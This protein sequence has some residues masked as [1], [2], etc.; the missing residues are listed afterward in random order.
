MIATWPRLAEFAA[1]L[2][3]PLDDFQTEACRAVE[4]GRG[5]LVA[6][7]TG[8]GKTIVGEFAVHLAL[9]TGRKAFYTTPI[10]AL[11]NQKYADLVRR[12]GADRVGLL[13]GDSSINGEAPIV[14]M[15]TEVLRNMMYA[16]STTLRG[17][18]CV[19]MDEV[20]YLADRFR[21]AVWEE[22]IIHLPPEVQRRV[23]VGD[24]E[25]R[26]G[27]RRLARGGARRRRG[28]RL[29]APSRASV[30]A[31]DGRPGPLRPVRRGA[32]DGRADDEHSWPPGSL[33]GE[34]QPRPR[35]RHPRHRAS[36]RV[37]HAR[38]AARGS[39]QGPSRGKGGGARPG[40]GGAADGTTGPGEVGAAP[41]PGAGPVAATADAAS[42]AVASRWRGHARRGRRSGSTATDCCRRSPSSSAARAATAPSGSCCRAACA[43]SPSPEGEAHPSPRRGARPGL[44]GREED[45]TVLGYWDFVD[46]LD[47]RVRRP[48]RRDAA[49]LPRD[50]R[51]AVH[52]RPGPGRLRDRDAGAGHQHAGADGRAREAGEVQRRGPRRRHP[53]RVHPA[54][55]PGRAPGHR[56]RGPCRRAVEPRPRPAGR[57][58]P[59]LD[60]HLPAA[61][62]LPAD[63]QHGRQPRAPSSVGSGAREILETSFAQFQADRAVVGLRPHDPPQRGGP[64]RLRRAR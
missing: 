64:C 30:A 4:E 48:P 34:R 10:K 46:G 29:G 42:P 25:Q 47:P 32:S 31:H 21:G 57:R 35:A 20:H 61:V 22:V 19:V 58:R 16:G 5:V 33:L 6:A 45:L 43:S 39:R 37:G 2:E 23:A 27:V 15:T 41:S 51:G 36:R 18:G 63:V 53:G 17:L 1:R 13:T 14:V 59:R 52:R 56:H 49:D 28:D 62:E 44:A 9:A 55:R 3:F 24:G 8:A 60:P 40:A 54:D 12:H 11:S 7:P 50:R 26:R 38:L